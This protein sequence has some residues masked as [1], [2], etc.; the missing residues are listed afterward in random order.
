MSS[1]KTIAERYRDAYKELKPLLKYLES[2]RASTQ[3]EVDFKA[4]DT[5][6]ISVTEWVTPGGRYAPG[7]PTT[8]ENMVKKFKKIKENVEKYLATK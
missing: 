1:N 6:L 7:H 2:A 4:Y 5:N 8:A 3:H